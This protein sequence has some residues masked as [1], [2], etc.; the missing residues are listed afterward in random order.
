MVQ[1]FVRFA[2]EQEKV[3]MVVK[4]QGVVHVMDIPNVVLVKVQVIRL[5]MKMLE[6]N[7]K[8]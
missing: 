4:F 6:N 8:T 1:G 5:L 2:R 3:Y 7:P